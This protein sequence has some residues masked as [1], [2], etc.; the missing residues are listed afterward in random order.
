MK[1]L[2]E[3]DRITQTVEIPSEVVNNAKMQGRAERLR[4]YIYTELAHKLAEKLMESG[5]IAETWLMRESS[6]ECTATLYV[7]PLIEKE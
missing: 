7:K 2:G 4:K 6:A 1:N 5:Y 3:Y